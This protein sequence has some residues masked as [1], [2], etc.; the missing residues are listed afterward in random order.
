MVIKFINARHRREHYAYP[1]QQ[2]SGTM[3]KRLT[4]AYGRTLVTSRIFVF[5]SLAILAAILIVFTSSPASA[6][7]GLV[8]L[9]AAYLV[10]F[11]VSPLLTQHW[12]TRSRVI[13]RQGWYFRAVLPFSGIEE[14]VAADDAH[15]FRTPL[16]ISR[17]FGQPVLFA[18]SPLLT[19][20]WITRSRVILRQGW[21][22]RAVLPFSGI[23]ELV[24]ADDAHTFRTPL[25]ISR[26]FGQ[27]VLFV[28]GG[29]T[30]LVRVRLRRPRRFWQ[31]FGLSA[32][33]IVFDVTDRDGFLAA[34]EERRRLCPPVQSDRAR[35]DF[36]D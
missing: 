12:I 1:K 33:E 7:I 36:R 6:V 3:E 13:L 22:F 20:H 14:L 8:A 29:R 15:T 2:E 17:P 18:V 34:F 16:G 25:G 35:A 9:L 24:A 21:Y 11:A 30:N 5:A 27:P 26:P 19:Q 10:L 32:A 4:F 28:T 31:A 23:E